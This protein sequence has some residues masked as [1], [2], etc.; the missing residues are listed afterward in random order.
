MYS[1]KNGP[2]SF[3]DL[4]QG[5][6]WQQLLAIVIG[7]LP[8]YSSMILFQ[9]R[10]GEPISM[11]G[12]ILYLAIIAPLTILVA[13][14]L[15]RFLCGESP[16]D[17]NLRPGKLPSDIRDALLLSLV[18]I[19]ANVAS[20]SFFSELLP[21]SPSD[22]SVRNLFAEL[23][24]DPGLLILFLGLLLPLGAASEEVVRVFLLSRLWKIWP[25]TAGKFVAVVISACLFGL[26]HLYRGP[27]GASSAGVFGLITGLYYLR[28]G[29]AV[30]LIIAHYLTN[31]L[32]VVV[33]AVLAR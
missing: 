24:G 31:A 12:F 29:R 5:K 17:L 27:V 1:A 20:T 13:L 7:V 16:R 28:Y 33:F 19:V 18:I 4:R 8:L 15:L 6:A 21:E 22:P 32:Q 30:P 2:T 26:V 9:L 25:S 3:S 23:A 14:L 11:Q 10:R